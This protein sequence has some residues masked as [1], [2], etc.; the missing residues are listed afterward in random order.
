MTGKKKAVGQV[1]RELREGAQISQEALGD[2]AGIHRTYVSQLERGVKS[3][4]LA[5]LQRIADALGTKASEIVRKTEE[6]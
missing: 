5:I 1:I 6:S 4:T 3:P 2:R